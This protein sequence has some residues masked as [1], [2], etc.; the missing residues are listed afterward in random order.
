MR[1]YLTTAA[2][3]MMLVACVAGDD[4][5]TID[6]TA[7]DSP[8]TAT[9][10]DPPVMVNVRDATGRELGVIALTDAAGGISVTGRLTGLPP[11]DHGIHIHMIGRC[12]APTFESAGEHWNPT[13]VKHGIENP[14]GPHLGDMP[15]VTVSAD[16]TTTVQVVTPGGS[17]RGANLLLDTDGAALIIHTMRDDNRT[18]PSGGSGTPWACGVI[19]GP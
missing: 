17:L 14:Q 1:T 3:A 7:A 16:S 12:D 11:G 4:G 6:S 10:P 18:D 5:A 9:A 19:S 8:A 2:G 15:N 13:S